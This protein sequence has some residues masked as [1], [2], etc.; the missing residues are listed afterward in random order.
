MLLAHT[1]EAIA[2]CRGCVVVPTM[3]ALH[4]GHA[5]LIRAA[6]AASRERARGGA[7]PPVVVTVFV[8]PTQFNDP[9]DLAR[10]PRTLE[11]DAALCEREGA[12]AVF[13]PSA[14]IMYPPGRE[15]PVPLLP[16]VATAPGLEDAWR[17][18]HFA[19][20]CQVVR[21]RFDL[22]APIAAVFGEKDWQQ[23][24]VVRA[25]AERDT[26]GVEIVPCPTVREGDGLA[27][28]SRNRFLSP[29]DR[30]RA[31]T[32]PGALRAAC[33]APTPGA[34]ERAMTETLEHEGL[35]VQYAV[36]REARSLRPILPDAARR[37]L[38]SPARALIAVECG[39]IRLIDNCAWPEGAP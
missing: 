7:R 14:A 11:A 1:I 3:G 27:L 10:Y 37:S 15:I 21:R 18:G 13:A 39:P 26:P 30:E 12:D 38:A 23:L 22:L 33:A 9:G 24:Q 36:V 19:G 25:M 28:S 8:N 2:P 29:T 5:A 4:E 20:V 34:A 17:P 31:A 6:L 35:R 32:V 16:E